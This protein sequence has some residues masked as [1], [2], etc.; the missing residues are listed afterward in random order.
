MLDQNLL[1]F[2]P[3]LNLKKLGAKMS[4]RPRHQKGWLKLDANGQWVAHWY[5]YVRVED[6]TE[7]RRRRKRVLG[8][9]LKRWQA[10]VDGMA[11]LLF[12]VTEGNGRVN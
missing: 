2:A 5:A 4:P 3:S 12:P 8:K 10:A 6:G 9:K 7:K 1:D 11:E